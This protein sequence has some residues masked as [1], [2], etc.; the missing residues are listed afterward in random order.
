M[1]LNGR[2]AAIVLAMVAII[3]IGMDF[4]V[5]ASQY[6][7]Q[8]TWTWHKTT[9]EHGP[10]DKTETV[11]AN[12]FLLGNS[13]YE[14]VGS[15][16]DTEIGG[17]AFGTGTAMLVGNNLIMTL[18]F[19]KIRSDGRQETGIFQGQVNKTT[20]NG[21]GWAIKKRFDP[22]TIGT[23]IIF[24]DKY[25]AGTLTLVGNPP[26]LGP[27]SMAPMQMLLLDDK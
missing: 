4:R 1:K 17:T 12:L 21:T 6:L 11:V 23:T 14:L 13:C 2:A 19:S 20:F 5:E 7:G 15:T 9:D 27:T 22:A 8:V 16:T 26:P 3:I 24:T 25:L 10:T 18:S